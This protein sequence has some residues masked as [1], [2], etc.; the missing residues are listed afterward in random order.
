MTDDA[1][2]ILI[3]DIARNVVERD[4]RISAASEPVRL[5]AEGGDQMAFR[6]NKTI[7]EI[8]SRGRHVAKIDTQIVSHLGSLCFSVTLWHYDPAVL[9]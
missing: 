1:M 8:R 7:D 5:F 6:V 9:G 2:S 3:A 4:F